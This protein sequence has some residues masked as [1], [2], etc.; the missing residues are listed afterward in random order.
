MKRPLLGEEGDEKSAKDEMIDMA[1]NAIQL[2]STKIV[3]ILLTTIS[4]AFLG[5][6]I[7]CSSLGRHSLRVLVG[8]V[9]GP[10]QHLLPPTRVSR[11]DA[12]ATWGR[13]SWRRS[14]SRRSI[15]GRTLPSCSS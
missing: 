10:G 5:E 15:S 1:G 4:V 2:S 11:V 8:S 9:I 6:R 3:T 13:S 7:E 12:Q 14:R